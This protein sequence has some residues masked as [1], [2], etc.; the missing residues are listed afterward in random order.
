MNNIHYC[1]NIIF[2]NLKNKYLNIN[3][4][5]SNKFFDGVYNFT[6]DIF[7]Q[8]LI[9]FQGKTIG[10]DVTF[11]I[12]MEEFF[13]DNNN[14]II[15]KK[16]G[17]ENNEY[18]ELS[19]KLTKEISKKDKKNNGI[20][21]SP[22]SSIKKMTHMIKGIKNIHIKHILEPSCGSCE[23]IQYMNKHFNNLII[24]AVE[25]NDII[26]NSLKDINIHNVTFIHKNYL[27]FDNNKKYDLI[28]GNPPYFVMKKEEVDKKYWDYFTG[29]PNIF[30]IFIIHS[31]NKLN[32]NG[33]LS[34]ILPINFLNCSYYDN[35]RK[36]IYLNYKII[37]IIDC[38][39]DKYIE[40][41]QDTIIFCIQ[42]TKP[43]KN[44]KFTMLYNNFTIF[45]T[46]S[47]IVNLKELTENSF[48][49]N[50]LDLSVS[51]GNV[52]WN[53]EKDKLTKDKKNTRLIYNSDIVNGEL[54]FKEYK[55]KE[56]KNFIKKEGKRN[57]VI[58][59][60]RGYAAGNYSF[61]YYLLNI[62][63][64]YLLENHIIYIH[65]QK[66]IET[67][68]LLK[69]LKKIIISF[70]NPKTKKFIELYFGNNNMNTTE[71]E[72]I[73]PIYC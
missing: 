66:N 15:E 53:Q 16:G 73:L 29:R 34:F 32:K 41:Q 28:I 18:S 61:E 70:E 7:N 36:H 9:I 4:Y 62:R 59:V 22:V 42:N 8:L 55:N 43:D 57:P 17:Q 58:I 64:Q 38:S 67:N 26:F 3:K 11:D 51:V 50:S 12:L 1:N 63:K 69:L 56:K 24:D 27:H 10:K 31:L 65:P 21:F 6:E 33:I 71:L 14:L 35:L 44:E 25:Y 45:N 49:L 72:Y 13:E 48:N 46:P 40:T 39:N 60:N 23:V 30:L 2:K 19:Y 54:V 37:D 68:E 52:V 20:F 47:N 5:M